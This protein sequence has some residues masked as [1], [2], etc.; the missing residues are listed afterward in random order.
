MYKKFYKIYKTL[1]EEKEK[2]SE[3][4]LEKSDKICSALKM[5]FLLMLLFLKNAG[6]F[7]ETLDDLFEICKNSINNEEDE[8]WGRIYTDIVLSQLSRGK[9]KL[10]LFIK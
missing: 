5:A 7:N 8:D 4:Y 2:T 1:N 9:S 3:A 10:M 6:E